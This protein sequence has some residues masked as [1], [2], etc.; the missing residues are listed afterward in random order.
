[1]TLINNDGKPLN[2]N[3]GQINAFLN[4]INYTGNNKL[5]ISNA[6][7]NK[8]RHDQLIDQGETIDV[9]SIDSTGIK[10]KSFF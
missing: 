2:L 7:K 9:K 1:M 3:R 8:D 6:T 5:K 10:L 4:L